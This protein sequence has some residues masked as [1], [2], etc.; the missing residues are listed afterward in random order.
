MEGGKNQNFSM[1]FG[2][3]LELIIKIW[4][5]VERSGELEPFFSWKILPIGQNH[6]FQVG[7]WQKFASKRN[8]CL[9]SFP[10]CKIMSLSNPFELTRIMT[11]RYFEDWVCQILG[12]RLHTGRLP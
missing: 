8:A 12:P 10:S 9:N 3:L 11:F 5:L 2:Y 7:N 6:I 1:F 4:Q